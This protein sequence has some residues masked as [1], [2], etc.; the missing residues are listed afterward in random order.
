M[1]SDYA[2]FL[3]SLPKHSTEEIL[4]YQYADEKW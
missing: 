1:E 4:E 2:Q 3:F